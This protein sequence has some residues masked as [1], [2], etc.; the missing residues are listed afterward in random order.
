MIDREHLRL[1]GILQ[2][3]GQR[4]LDCRGVDL[5]HIVIEDDD[6]ASEA[7]RQAQTSGI[8]GWWI[9]WDWVKIAYEP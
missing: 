8:P 9:E 1:W 4:Q 7:W 3:H 6:I 5:R 2:L